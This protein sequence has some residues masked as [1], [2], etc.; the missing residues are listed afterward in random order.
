MTASAAAVVGTQFW[1]PQE[2]GVYLLW[3]L[4]LVLMVVF[5]PR[6]VHLTPPAAVDADE[7][8]ISRAPSSSLPRTAGG[9]NLISRARLFR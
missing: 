6:L 1:Y 9:S 3:Y 7:Q 2:G 5:R 4:P 8:T